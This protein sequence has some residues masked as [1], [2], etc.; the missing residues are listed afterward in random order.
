MVLAPS[1]GLNDYSGDPPLTCYDLLHD[2]NFLC[3]CKELTHVDS[4]L[5]LF[6]HHCTVLEDS[7]FEQVDEGVQGGW[8]YVYQGDPRACGLDGLGTG[9]PGFS[10]EDC[11]RTRS[12]PAHDGTPGM[13]TQAYGR[14]LSPAGSSTQ[15]SGPVEYSIHHP[16]KCSNPSSSSA[17]LY[18]ARAGLDDSTIQSLNPPGDHIMITPELKACRHCPYRGSA[19]GITYVEGYSLKKYF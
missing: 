19:H 14:P 4:L 15:I 9:F 10:P 8:D 18:G 17:S 1:G 2:C 12:D 6:D 3:D 16:S 5:P 7:G 13:N 11:L